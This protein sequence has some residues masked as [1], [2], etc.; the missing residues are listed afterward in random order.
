MRGTGLEKQ[1]CAQHSVSAMHIDC[2]RHHDQ[3]RKRRNILKEIK[4][5][6]LPLAGPAGELRWIC[7]IA[8]G[9]CNAPTEN[10]GYN[11]RDPQYRR[12][13]RCQCQVEKFRGYHEFLA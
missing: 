7:R 2:L 6:S 8:C 4:V 3:R 5:R 9:V 1:G 11:L 13:T 12:Q 10:P